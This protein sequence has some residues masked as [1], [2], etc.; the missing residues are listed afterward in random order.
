MSEPTTLAEAV[1]AVQAAALE[2][3]L[4]REGEAEKG[5]AR[6]RRYLTY[7]KLL[8]ELQPLLTANK[9][10]WQTFPTTLDGKP[11][12]AYKLRFVPTDEADEGVMLLM[13]DKATSQAQGSAQTY[14]RRYS[15]QN[16]L[17]LTP[18][19]D[20]DG[21]EASAPARPAPVDPESPMSERNVASMYE[22]I[23]ERGLDVDAVLGRVELPSGAA[24][25]VEHGLAVKKLLDEHDAKDA[26]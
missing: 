17:N 20:D 18:D 8:R 14:A 4:R 24:P 9:L 6:F 7:P 3:D 2:L 16:V 26:E 22:A 23:A 13:L 5:S 15:L 11:A 19:G 10:T 1:L 12:L 25:L 21:Q